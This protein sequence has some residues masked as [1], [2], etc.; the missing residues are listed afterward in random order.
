MISG[1]KIAD[2]LSMAEIRE[3]KKKRFTRKSPLTLKRAG[4]PIPVKVE[5]CERVFW[6]FSMRKG[7]TLRGSS[8]LEK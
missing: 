1:I 2:E 6:L 5:D 8:S 7:L 3:F 4:F